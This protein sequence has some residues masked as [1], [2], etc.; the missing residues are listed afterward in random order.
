MSP[1]THFETICCMCISSSFCLGDGSDERASVLEDTPV[2]IA[3]SD[4]DESFLIGGA[5]QDKQLDQKRA[6][7]PALRK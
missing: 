2:S 7:L 6:K 1:F 4:V 5:S 3:P